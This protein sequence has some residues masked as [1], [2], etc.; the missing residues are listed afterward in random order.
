ML[1][2]T[3]CGLAMAECE[4]VVCD[5]FQIKVAVDV[6]FFLYNLPCLTIS[7]N[8]IIHLLLVDIVFFH[9]VAFYYTF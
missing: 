7:N 2:L 3:M 8:F 6:V 5:P 4:L 1:N 9:P